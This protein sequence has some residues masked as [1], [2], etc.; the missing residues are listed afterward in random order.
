MRQPV[1]RRRSLR[2]V[3]I[4]V[5]AITYVLATAGV[6]FAFYFGSRDISERYA[7]RYALS[8]NSLEKNRILSLVERELALS[9]KL[10]DDPVV[11]AWML[12]ERDPRLE[13]AA[14]AQLESYRR[15]LR[16]GAYFIAVKSSGRYYART[17]GVTATLTSVLSPANPADRWFFRT[18]QENKEYS[19]NVDHNALLRESR[20][21]INVTVRGEDGSATGVAG[22]GMDLTAFLDTLIEHEDPGVSTVI[23]DGSGALI[24]HPDRRL[25]A[26]NAEATNDA[27]KKSVYDL[28]SFEEDKRVLKE[29][30]SAARG[31]EEAGS[32]FP[33]R[34]GGKTV[35]CAVGALP[36]LGWL[37]VVLLDVA[38][39]IGPS[40]FMPIAAAVFL[41]LLL[42]SLSVVV[43]MER[44]ILKPL[45][46]LN[47][48]AGLVA[49]GAYDVALPVRSGDEIGELSASFNVM[50]DTVRRYTE[51]LENA[52]A[53]RTRELSDANRSILDSIRY[54]A[55]I[56]DSILPSQADLS[57]LVSDHFIIF[58]PRDLVGGDFVFFRIMED[59]F[60]L[61]VVDCT[62]HGVPG[63]L[64]TMMANAA[65]QRAAETSG[66]ASSA[67]LLSRV[68]SIARETLRGSGASGR[69]DNGFDIALCRYRKAADVMEFSGGGLSLVVA[70]GGEVVE[71]HGDRAGLGYARTPLDYRWTLRRIERASGAAFYLASDGVLDLPGGERGFGLG[72]ARLV[73]AIRGVSGMGMRDQGQALEDELDAYRGTSAPKDD[74]TFVGFRIDRGGSA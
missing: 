14:Y 44:V 46:E 50:T 21:W 7:E 66:D 51:G 30:V 5:I 61:A 64:M 56:Q 9:L 55:L 57:G 22:C 33:L 29:R 36:E 41:S 52:V 47:K 12:D 48:A 74:L 71:M 19:L 3:F 43:L 16:D 42:V 59:G 18:L 40:D 53:E 17:P 1:P 70:R 54:A 23:I 37:N 65:L 63:A 25:I 15:F 34:V 69:P 73:Q 27:D 72:R 62:G 67:E 13:G 68:H 24:A 39:I 38:R 2:A 49:D 6:F 58:R 35:L 4:S 8:Q 26:L 60:C 20:V 11:R 10:A 28:L 31:G 32:A 45:G